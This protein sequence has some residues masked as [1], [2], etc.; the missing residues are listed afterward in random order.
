MQSDGNKLNNKVTRLA[1][2]GLRNNQH[3]INSPLGKLITYYTAL[4][5]EVRGFFISA[6]AV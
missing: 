5:Y 3:L 6:R 1:I 4:F 2:S